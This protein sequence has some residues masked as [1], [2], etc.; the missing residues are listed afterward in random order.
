MA[1]SPRPHGSETNC[2]QIDAGTMCRATSSPRVPRG[3]QTVFGSG[4]ANMPAVSVS[5]EG[6]SERPRNYDEYLRMRAEL[7]LQRDTILKEMTQNGIAMLDLHSLGALIIGCR[8]VPETCR[9]NQAD[10]QG[11]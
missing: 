1:R 5:A 4:A 9:L 2:E 11:A 10:T 6:Q 7:R 8:T 3:H